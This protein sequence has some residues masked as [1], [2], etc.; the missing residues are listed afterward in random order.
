MPQPP[1]PDRAMDVTVSP[2]A[3]FYASPMKVLEYMSMGKAV[4]APAMDNI[5]DIIDD[6][7][8]GLLFEPG[9]AVALAS[10]IRRMIADEG[11]RRRLG[12]QARRRI[13][14]RLNW[15]QNARRI[16]EA[17]ARSV[18]PDTDEEQRRPGTFRR[19]ERPETQ[20]QP[21]TRRKSRRE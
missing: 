18:V 4:V 5:R 14:E 21:V 19:I 8:S 12:E 16:I 2:Q 6:E 17:A 15:R 7:E 11:L 10:A 20:Q 9:S 3:T 13:V 1:E